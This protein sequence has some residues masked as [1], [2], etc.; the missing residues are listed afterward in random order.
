MLLR[1]LLIA[2]LA[3]IFLGGLAAIFLVGPLRWRAEIVFDKAIGHLND[4]EWKDLKWLL[5]RGS[6]VDLK[7]LADTKNPYMAIESPLNSTSDVAAGE[8][9]F[10][11]NCALCHGD[12]A[13]G[14]PG[15]P[16]LHTRI[17]RR[18]RSD[19]ALYQTITLGLPG[20]AMPGRQMARDDVWQLVSYL[21]RSIVEQSESTT[22]SGSATTEI[23]IVPV[24]AAD[25]RASE[26]HP[27][28][29]LTY[30]GSYNS[31][32]HS[33][34]DQ[35]NRQNVSQL[36][37]EWERQFSTSVEHVE[38]SPIVRGSTMFVTEPPNRVL[39]LDAASGRVLWTFSRDLP[40]R[41]PL[42]CGPVNRGVAILG[43]RVFV[44]TLD[45]HLIAL[46]ASTGKVVWDV[47]VADNSNGYSITGAPLALEDMVVTGV[48]GGEFG[49]R[50]F[51]DAY[52]AATGKRRWR[53]YTIPAV[54]EPGSETWEDGSNRTGGAPTWL[55]GSYDPDLRLIYWG[56]GNPNPNYDGSGRN[57]D[58]L[59]SNSAVALDADT[60]KLRW[61][62]QFSPHD[63]H[64]WDS[65]QIPVLIDAVVDGSKR[66]LMA[67]SNRN[68]F[69]YLLDRTTG[70]FLLG[71]PYVKQ[72]WTEGLDEN[73]RPHIRPEAVPSREGSL[74]YPSLYGGTIWWSP[75]YDAQLEL[76]YVPTVDRGGIFYA[77]PGQPAS[78]EGF[79]L[80]GLHTRV[81]N[82]DTVVAIKALELTTGHVRW[83]YLRPP[84][85]A[86]DNLGGLIS[87]AGG[88]IFGGEAESLFALDSKTGAELWH[89]EA[90]GGV[91]AAPVTYQLAGRQYIAVA[92]GRSILAFALPPSDARKSAPASAH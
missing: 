69:Y 50:G 82:E 54:G 53:F 34:L 77:V 31:H 86:I 24:N 68:G 15:G 49:I 67:W 37:V 12:Q 9:L 57:G 14:G 13:I 22:S 17:F 71:T 25:L 52:D 89:F 5:G 4:L 20:T 21:K 83:Q 23:P 56:V 6:P 60:G 28:E 27:E 36:R 75:T 40:S 19:W 87:T 44:G 48:G 10:R 58:N 1:R 7:V 61:H 29:W 16:S 2:I 65:T 90:G 30:S 80:G 46:D 74:V 32:R 64:D 43:D 73:G 92:A 62:F 66:K 79:N 81:P 39:A 55:T 85:K 78:A 91:V 76:V 11:Q 35:I 72:N 18:G 84:V 38:T 45:A 41:L 3:L 8:Q 42:C 88:I 59:Y 26:D 51:V 63:A 70:K 47:A 33:R